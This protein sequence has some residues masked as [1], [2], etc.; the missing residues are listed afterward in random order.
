ML[1][2]PSLLFLYGLPGSGKSTTAQLLAQHY[3]FHWIEGD[4][5]LTPALKTAISAGTAL[6]AHWWATFDAQLIERIQ[7]AQQHHSHIT[8]SQ[9][10]FTPERRSRYQR[11]FPQATWWHID[12]PPALRHDRLVRRNNDVT[13]AYARKISTHFNPDLTHATLTNRSDN[14]VTLLKHIQL[15]LETTPE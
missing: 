12:A 10:L 6:Q 3:H 5:W 9:A 13:P 8:V 4:D 14:T 1:E 7:A 15:L 11:T 2:H